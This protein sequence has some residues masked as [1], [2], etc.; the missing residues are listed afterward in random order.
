MFISLKRSE[1]R[2]ISAIMEEAESSVIMDH[3]MEKFD[4]SKAPRQTGM[5][6]IVGGNK[7]TKKGF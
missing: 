4:P 3:I 5:S 2:R 6:W 7:Q 1:E